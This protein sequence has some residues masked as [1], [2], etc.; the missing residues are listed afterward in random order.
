MSVRNVMCNTSTSSHQ[1]HVLS[2]G[3]TPHTLVVLCR[4][5]PVSRPLLG[6]ISNHTPITLNLSS[7]DTDNGIV[8]CFCDW[9]HTLWTGW[10]MDIS[11]FVTDSVISLSPS[12]IFPPHK[13]ERQGLTCQR[14]KQLLR[15]QLQRL[16]VMIHSSRPLPNHPL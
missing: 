13:A 8:H 6:I 10:H 9:S 5:Y 14:Q 12:V 15:F 4:A 2:I 7:L 3:Y 1:S 16:L 11:S